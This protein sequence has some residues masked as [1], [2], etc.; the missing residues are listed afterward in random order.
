MVLRNLLVHVL[1]G[2][3]RSGQQQAT[4][5]PASSELPV[6][7]VCVSFDARLGRS[8]KVSDSTVTRLIAGIERAWAKGYAQGYKDGLKDGV[9]TEPVATDLDNDPSWDESNNANCIQYSERHLAHAWNIEGHSPTYWCDGRGV[10][11]MG[12]EQ[13]FYNSGVYRLHMKCGSNLEHAEHY[14]TDEQDG[15][16]KW[17]GK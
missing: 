11:V 4:L 10:D 9:K 2:R 13:T 8:I 7:Q 14:W 17:C 1:R 6:R 5:Q 12:V 16:R 15:K 3:T